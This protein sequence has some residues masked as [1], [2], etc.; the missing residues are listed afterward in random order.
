M[1]KDE[2]VKSSKKPDSDNVATMVWSQNLPE[3]A[4]NWNS[5]H[6]IE[7]QAHAALNRTTAELLIIRYR[8]KEKKETGNDT[9][10][11]KK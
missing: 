8:S 5:N 3:N 9:K 2:E 6:N 11:S 4:F 10:W 1:P 7:T